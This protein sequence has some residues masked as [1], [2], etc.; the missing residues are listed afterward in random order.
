MSIS[1][2][3]AQA[4]AVAAFL[5]RH[6]ATRSQIVPLAS[7]WA[8]RTYFRLSED[9][10]PSRVLMVCQDAL[11][12]A[13][14]PHF[15]AIAKGLRDHGIATPV[16]HDVDL[17]A[18]LMLLEDFGD[19]T[20]TRQMNQ[21]VQQQAGLY[22]LATDVL[23]KLHDLPKNVWDQLPH[24]NDSPVAKGHRRVLDWYF[25]AVTRTVPSD[26]LFAAYHA[27]TDRMLG[28]MP[29]LPDGFIH[30]DYHPENLMYRPLETG[31]AQAGLLD[32]QAAT[33]GAGVYDLSNLL[34]DIRRD[35]PDDI[36]QA[37]LAKYLSVYPQSL[38]E[39]IKG[40]FRLYALLYHLRIMGQVIKLAIRAG[41]DQL[42]DFQ[43]R[44]ARY[45]SAELANPDFAALQTFFDD[46][47]LDFTA[48]VA[49]GDLE[50][51]KPFIR[52][53]AF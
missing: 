15:I 51:I 52:D 19:I 22:G 46:A 30:V 21:V 12:K 3:D 17:A 29:A 1:L 33:R 26:G 6:N 16:V 32:F 37:C 8:A 47:G 11:T 9:H 53:D 7:D 14:M 43:P 36:R 45:L 48:T 35:V 2:S 25:P 41:R 28:A 27:I 5:A 40:W 13:E 42:L 34:C 38:H 24:F 49:P 4:D 31:L 10:A 23:C 18:G 50:G 39:D 20:F 44:V